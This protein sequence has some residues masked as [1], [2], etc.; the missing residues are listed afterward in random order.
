MLES[1]NC[2][3]FS[4][5]PDS[6]YARNV[7]HVIPPDKMR[8]KEGFLVITNER[9]VDDEVL[10]TRVIKWPEIS[11]FGSDARVQS[12]WC[13][14]DLR[15]SRTGIVCDYDLFLEASL[16]ENKQ[17]LVGLQDFLSS[18][19]PAYL[20]PAVGS[21]VGAIPLCAVSPSHGLIFRAFDYNML[22]LHRGID[23]SVNA[24]LGNQQL[25]Q[26]DGWYRGQKG[27]E[28]RMNLASH[29]A[30]LEIKRDMIFGD[31]TISS[32]AGIEVSPTDFTALHNNLMET[33][34]KADVISEKVLRRFV[35]PYVRVKVTRSSPIS[36]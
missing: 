1:E 9:I 10:D 25:G 30:F 14:L 36:S 24:L 31:V 26:K 34:E 11:E 7:Q 20:L 18:L 19:T 23:P 15:K 21:V 4:F 22:L 12:G 5:Y 35:N 16:E 27:L 6:A 32:I 13:T 29:P 3:L 17:D 8:T 2:P 28:S 33:F